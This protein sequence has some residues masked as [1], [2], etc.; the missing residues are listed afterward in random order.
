MLLVIAGIVKEG[1]ESC[2]QERV[3][4]RKVRVTFLAVNASYS[5]SSLAAWC[6]RSMMDANRV[7][8]QQV[9]ATVN[10]EPQAVLERV[11]ASSPDIVATTLYLF[12]RRIIQGLLGR[13]REVRPDCLLVAG[14]PECL[15][16][17]RNLVGGV[18]DMAV[19]GEGE[20]AFAELV[21][22]WG[23][24]E[25]VFCIPGVCGM[26]DGV[27][28]DN[29]IAEV[30]ELDEMPNYYPAMLAGF[31]RP[32]VQ[33]ETSRGCPNG[34]LFCTSRKT[35]VRYKSL[36]RV[37]AELEAIRGAG[38]RTV[39]LVDRTFNLVTRRSLMLLRLFRDEFP[40]MRFHL[41]IDPGVMSDEVSEEIGHA[42]P[43]TLH[44]EVGVQSLEDEVHSILQRRATPQQTL[45]G[46]Q[47]LA[48]L[49]G[50]ELHADLMS[51][52]PGQT[53]NGLLEDVRS[54]VQTGV[55]EIQLERL[56]LLPGTPLAEKP[57]AWGLVA[58]TWP[59]YQ[60]LETPDM[61]ADDLRQADGLAKILDWFHNKP[62]LREVFVVGAGECEGFLMAFVHHCGMTTG[63][64]IC[65]SLE[66]R[67]RLLDSFWEGRSAFMTHR[68]RYLWFRHGC[69]TRHGP[70]PAEP[71]K[72]M[73]PEDAVLVEG[74][75]EADFSKIWRV[76]LD[77]PHYFCFGKGDKG[78]RAVLAVFK[79]G[80]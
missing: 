32:F 45:E 50:V 34:C 11:V 65:P 42:A 31:K 22:R 26:E 35:T 37:R 46:V 25:S 44:L 47:R 62:L 64:G 8:W 58:K 23:R 40:G 49:N 80:G 79:G 17:N 29:G 14:G 1:M 66:A 28:R 72:A 75:E 3:H 71:W 56:K 6:L 52:L 59:P 33:L 53:L 70:C 41:E 73:I 38:V 36:E 19:R 39:R 43:G 2:Q 74:D 4:E 18:V 69:S 24:G 54:L 76:Q 20:R 7:D 67:L 78:E 63:F 12:N 77:R 5:H 13:F 55:K 30:V 60:V 9:E 51:G 15:G 61:S 27:Y 10:D 16:D 57:E 48:A 21:R 68:V